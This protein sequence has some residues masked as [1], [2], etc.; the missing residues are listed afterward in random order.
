M[1]LIKLLIDVPIL[2]GIILIAFASGFLLRSTQ[3]KKQKKKVLELEKEMMSSHA[4][5]LDLQKERL[6]LEEKLKGSSKIP[7]IPISTKEEKKS[8]KLQD[9]SAGKK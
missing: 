2:A 7:V 6:E 1:L 4:E 8:D 3:L 9:K 5:I